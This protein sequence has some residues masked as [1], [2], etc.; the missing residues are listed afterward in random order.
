[1]LKKKQN[2]QFPDNMILYIEKPKDATRKLLEL[3]SEQSNVIGQKIHTH[4]SFAFPYTNN[5]NSVKEIKETILFTITIKR[6]KYL[7]IN[8]SKET[9]DLYG[10][11]YDTK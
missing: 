9:K 2:S 1:M 5:E 11:K 4:K 10:E 6:K 7:H 8:L 3:I